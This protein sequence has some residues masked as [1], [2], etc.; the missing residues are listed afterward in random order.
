MLSAAPASVPFSGTQTA[1][2]THALQLRERRHSRA[3]ELRELRNSCARELREPRNSHAPELTPGNSGACA[4]AGP[5]RAAVAGGTAWE[6]PAVKVAAGYKGSRRRLDISRA[7]SSRS[8]GMSACVKFRQAPRARW[9]AV[10]RRNTPQS[11]PF[12]YHTG[13][14][15][16]QEG[17]KCARN[18]G[19]H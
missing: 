8:S 10:H 7:T 4:V 17:Q 18:V 5:A 13:T 6:N 11:H 15:P 9:S 14:Q 16:R 3:G 2:S 1:E 19:V 12:F